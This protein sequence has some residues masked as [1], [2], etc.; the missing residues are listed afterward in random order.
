MDIF[1]V[2]EHIVWKACKFSL[3]RGIL[4]VP[5]SKREKSVLVDIV[6]VV[7]AF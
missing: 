1:N 3:E 5:E 2:S 4:T 6:Q 7:E